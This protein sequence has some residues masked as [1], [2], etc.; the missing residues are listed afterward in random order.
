MKTAV[1]QPYLFPYIGYWQLINS[2]DQFVILDDVN[3]I[4]RGYINRNSIL[5]NGKIYNFTIPIKK[6]SQNKLIMDTEINFSI[7]ERN[8]FLHTIENAYKKAPNYYQVKPIL[9]KII[10]YSKNDVTS[11]IENSIRVILDYLQL[12]TKIY[13]S[14]KIE[15]KQ[16]LKAQD[17]I[18]EICKRVGTDTYINSC[19][20]RVLYRHTDFE[21]EHIHL[22]F[23]DTRTEKIMYNQKKL[24][25]VKNLSIIDVLMF[26]DKDVIRA[27]LKEYDLNE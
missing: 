8:K 4:I 25:F 14:S 26:N 15:K 18:I 9:E 10:M 24:E 7:R 17:K 2:V 5:L 21:R 1:M 11:Y 22:L 13:I 23:L 19:G 3:F 20:G 12:D 6:A 16:E 27:F